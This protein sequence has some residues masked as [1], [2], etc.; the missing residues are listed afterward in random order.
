M[1][2]SGWVEVLIVVFFILVIA[3][4]IW[5]RRGINLEGDL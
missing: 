4:T 5:A 3:G 1:R 2:N